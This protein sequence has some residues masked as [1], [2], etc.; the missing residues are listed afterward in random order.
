MSSCK[1]VNFRQILVDI[2]FGSLIKN[3]EQID[4]EKDNV[5]SIE[6]DSCRMVPIVAKRL[7]DWRI[8]PAGGSTAIPDAHLSPIKSIS[9]I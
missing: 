8:A 6:P 4:I 2:R 7:G 1:I 9:C 3:I 5:V